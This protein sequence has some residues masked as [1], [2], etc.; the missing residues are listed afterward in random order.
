M[1]SVFESPM[2]G[3]PSGS[4]SGSTSLG[5]HDGQGAGDHDGP[6]TGFRRS[7]FTTRQLMRLLLLCGDA[8]DARPG[9]GRWAI[10]VRSLESHPW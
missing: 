4:A 9:Y 3:P 1:S 7:L 8:L 10:D 6:F 5:S 2:T